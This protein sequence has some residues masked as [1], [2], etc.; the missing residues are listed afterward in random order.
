MR[1]FTIIVPLQELNWNYIIQAVA[2]HLDSDTH[3][4]TMHYG[5]E[6]FMYDD[7]EEQPAVFDDPEAEVWAWV[8]LDDDDVPIVGWND[9]VNSIDNEPRSVD[10]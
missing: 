1:R 9:D 3:R 4:V 8:H 6:C 5:A 7:S 2:K 10:R